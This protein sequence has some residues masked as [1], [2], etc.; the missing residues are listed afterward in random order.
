M[1]LCMCVEARGKTEG[2]VADCSLLQFWDRV[3]KKKIVLNIY[4]CEE[5]VL[6][7]GGYTS[8]AVCVELGG[9]LWELVLSFYQ[10]VLG[11]ELRL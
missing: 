5:S 8:Y 6:G 11:I 3:F 4:V 10:R 7:C 1:L 2:A 9:S